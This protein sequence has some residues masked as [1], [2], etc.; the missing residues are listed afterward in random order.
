MSY[1]KKHA[2]WENKHLTNHNR[3]PPT[4]PL[5]DS[6]LLPPDS[7]RPLPILVTDRSLNQLRYHFSSNEIILFLLQMCDPLCLVLS[8]RGPEPGNT[9]LRS[10]PTVMQGLVKALRGSA[11]GESLT[12][13]LNPHSDW[14]YRWGHWEQNDSPTSWSKEAPEPKQGEGNSTRVW[15]GTCTESQNATPPGM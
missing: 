6:L 5:G 15:S 13:L 4:I 8:G 3:D 10:T 2:Q 12:A 9:G 14:T 1:G 7:R 11:V